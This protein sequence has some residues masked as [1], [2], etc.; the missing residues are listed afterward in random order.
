[1]VKVYPSIENYGNLLVASL[2]MDIFDGSPGVYCMFL[3][4]ADV[5]GF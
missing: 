2:V 3:E 4:Q 5:I 1:M